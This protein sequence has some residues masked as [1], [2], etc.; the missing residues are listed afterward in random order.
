MKA[1]TVTA[2]IERKKNTGDYSSVTFSTWITYEVEDGEQATDVL[3]H[4]MN[5]C[6]AQIVTSVAPFDKR[7]AVTIEE[8]FQGVKVNGGGD[9]D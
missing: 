2:H 6:Q 4:A 5:E 1:T 7:G 3:A 8:L 9:H